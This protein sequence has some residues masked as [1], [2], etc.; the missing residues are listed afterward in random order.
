MVAPDSLTTLPHLAISRDRNWSN[1]A[2][3]WRGA[4]VTAIAASLST[5][6]RIAQRGLD[7][8]VQGVDRGLRRARRA[9]PGRTSLWTRSRR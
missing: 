6:R 2:G 3:A 8:I 5:Y 1:C 4:G 9:R 7:R